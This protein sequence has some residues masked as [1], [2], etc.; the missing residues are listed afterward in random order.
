MILVIDVYLYAFIFC[1]HMAV[2]VYMYSY[3]VIIAIN[4]LVF[5]L[6]YGI[7]RYTYIM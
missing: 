5:I 1:D 3:F 2:D 6:H 7:N 4:V